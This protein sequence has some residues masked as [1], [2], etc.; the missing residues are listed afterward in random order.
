LEE[1]HDGRADAHQ[2]LVRV[3]LQSPRLQTQNCRLSHSM[4]AWLKATLVVMLIGMSM[5]MIGCGGCDKDEAATC[6]G[7]KG[8]KTFFKVHPR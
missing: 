4:V 6:D 5:L 1:R 2:I 7:G 8:C 3:A